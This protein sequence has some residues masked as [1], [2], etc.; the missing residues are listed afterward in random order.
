MIHSY[1]VDIQTNPQTNIHHWKHS[2]RF[3]MLCR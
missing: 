2:P 1:R 3:A